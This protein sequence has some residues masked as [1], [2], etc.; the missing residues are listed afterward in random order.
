M[1]IAE[2]EDLPPATQEQLFAELLDRDALK[3][4]EDGGNVNW[5]EEVRISL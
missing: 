2:I 5:S 4:L 1:G 3:E